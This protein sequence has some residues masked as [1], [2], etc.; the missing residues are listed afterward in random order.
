MK[1]LVF[2][3]CLM[4][5]CVNGW[6]QIK[7]NSRE[8]RIVVD[9][10]FDEGYSHWQWNP[11]NF[12]NVGD[13]SW[14]AYMS[15]TIIPKGERQV[16][17]F[18]NCQI[19][20]LNNTMQL[21]CEYDSLGRI[22][23]SNYYF[24]HWMKN[25]PSGEGR[26]FFSGAMEYYKQRYVSNDDDRKFKYGYFEIR[27]KLPVHPGAFPAFWLQ[28][29]SQDKNDSYYEE[30]DIFEYSRNLMHKNSGNPRRLPA[31]DTAR[32]FTTGVYHNLTGN[33]ANHTTESFARNFPVV[34]RTKNDLSDWHT[35]GCEWMPDH[36]YWFFDGKL[37][38]SYF[39]VNHIPKH[40]LE[41][42]VDYAIDTYAGTK[43]EEEWHPKWF[44]TDVM[45][46]DY[47]KV[48]EKK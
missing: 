35:F 4:Q 9:E 43:I 1:K 32:V 25:F 33:S 7:L 5:M 13:Y 37:V 36:I 8:W 41:L 46:I 22:A 12:C 17:Q 44:G 45:V 28:A 15:G 20:T 26:Y 23:D 39:D 21:I 48:Y 10:E 42:K 47:I 6:A 38:N 3:C 16:Y 2:F 27:C 24:P 31:K 30:I 14:K 11:Q 18:A 29:A 19:D 34:S 40:P